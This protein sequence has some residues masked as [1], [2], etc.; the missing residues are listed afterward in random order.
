MI[1]HG[2]RLPEPTSRFVG[3]SQEAAAIRDVLTRARLVTLTGPGGIGKTR[4][5]IRVAG[6][7]VRTFPDG[8][9]LA[10]LSAARDAAGVVRAVAAA[11]G[12]RGQTGSRGQ[13]SAGWL[14]GRLR[15]RRVLLI[16]DTCEHVVDACA[17]LADTIV[18]GAAEP[19]L[20]VTGRQPLDLPGEVVFRIPPLGVAD[21]ASEAVSLLADRGAAVPGFAVTPGTL[22]RLVDL[23]RLL[24]GMPLAIELAALRLRTADLDEL[25]GW[26]PGHLRQLGVGRPAAGVARHQSLHASVVWS[27]D[28]C[29]PAE[30]LLWARLSVFPGSFDLKAAEAVCGSGT[31]AFLPGPPRGVRG[32]VPPGDDRGS[33]TLAFLPDPPR[34]V[35]GVV[36][37]G[38]DRG[39]GT[40]AFLPGPPRGVR[41]VV[42]PGDDRGSG[43]LAAAEIVD[44]L[45]AL[46]DK[47]VVLREQDEGDAARYW[48]PRVEREHGA[49][50]ATDARVCAARHRGHYLDVAAAFAASFNGPGQPGLVAAL[51]RDEANLR[52]AFDGALAEGDGAMAAELAVAC[53][54]WLICTDRFGLVRSWLS[55]VSAG[56]RPPHRQFA[57]RLAWVTF[58]QGD[59]PTAGPLSD[60]P[61][62]GPFARLLDGLAAAM[63]A[64][65]H[66]AYADCAARCDQLTAVLPAD[67]RWARGWAAWLGG[68]AAWFDG[69]RDTAA[70]RL[71]SGLEL[72]VPFGGELAVAQHLEAFAWL[73][74]GAGDHRRTARLLGA[75]DRIWQRLAVREGVRAPRFGLALLDAERDVAA[76]QATD[77]LGAT[78]YTAEHAA[79]MALTTQAAAWN[80]VQAPPQARSGRGRAPAARQPGTVR[81]SGRA[82][83]ARPGGAGGAG[84]AAAAVPAQAGAA[85]SAARWALLT[86]REREVA[87]LVA[88]GLANK[89]IASRLVVSKRTVDAHIEHILGKLGYSSRVQIAALAAGQR[90]YGEGPPIPPPREPG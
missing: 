74:E 27:Y 13:P 14:A 41:G 86:A 6:E 44:T 46:V 12:S 65:R 69:D 49:E 85:E 36:P 26:L 28:L 90:D 75:A 89:D 17:D 82:P 67:E 33:G 88:G 87:A 22:P 50:F 7:A 30:R 1:T 79:G 80:A 61:A 34:R 52:L 23:C 9:F 60:G 5:A 21:G 66:D 20:L 18:H 35:R 37:P 31:L 71:R 38:D 15:G 2:G 4:L 51:A 83:G 16:L 84:S 8:V 77:A 78:R 32:V 68:V 25:L 72:L 70:E 76:R 58:I 53:W 54:P 48:L 81:G 40:L 59:A 19:V 24:D 43:M 63:D 55:A 10:D 11:V 47:S 3:R 56:P 57:G 29:T 62:A 39:S 64:L 45:V 42:P 73:A